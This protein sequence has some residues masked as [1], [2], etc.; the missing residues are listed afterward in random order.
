M[1]DDQVMFPLVSIVVTTKN[2]ERCI[3]NCIKSVISQTYPNIELIVV[4]NYSTDTTKIISRKYTDHVYDKGPERSAQRNYGMIHAAK[5]KYVMYVDADMTLSPSLV[6]EAVRKM[7]N[8]ISLVGLYIPLRWIGNNWII[9]CKG[10]E[11]E[12]Y[13]ASCLDAARFIKR[14]AFSE[15]GGFD[16]RLYGG[17]D[18]DLDRRI[19]RI[20]K[21]DAISSEMYHHEDEDLTLIKYLQKM[22]YYAQ[23]LDVYI[24][25]WGESDTTIRKQLGFWYRYFEIFLE[26]GKWRKLI[27]RPILAVGMYW[28]KFLTGFIFLSRRAWGKY[29]KNTAF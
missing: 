1:S 14:E 5:G 20:G 8:E 2:E 18:W 27:K 26:N 12:F 28:L 10:F 13:D 23:N 29:S 9:Q 6:S 24:Q 22:M 4:D 3:E 16:E 17:E 19:S 7:Q 15:V 25:K 11:R 21:I